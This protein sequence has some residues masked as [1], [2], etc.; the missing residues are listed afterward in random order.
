MAKF[1]PALLVILVAPVLLGSHCE[2]T[3]VRE[4]N[5]YQQEVEFME[6][7]VSQEAVLLADWIKT[8]CKCEEGKFTSALCE[9]SAKKVQLARARIAWHRDMMLYNAG[10]LK[11]RPS[12]TPP[13]VLEATV[14]CP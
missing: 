1:L 9:D 8:S 2:E 7:F 6:Q 12:E 14:L 10:L 5:T 3:V 11:D 13:V 4:S